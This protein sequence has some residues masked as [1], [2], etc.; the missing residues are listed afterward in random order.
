[1]RTCVV[2]MLLCTLA[3]GRAVAQEKD[4]DKEAEELY[5]GKTV[6]QLIGLL[7]S[8]DARVRWWAAQTLGEAGIE[9][10]PAVTALAATLKDT[11]PAVKVA[12]A[13]TLAGLGPE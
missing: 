6:K 7:K 13:K 10:K 12:A 4:K 11:I 1:M 9:A 2:A 5:Q 8:T 3:L